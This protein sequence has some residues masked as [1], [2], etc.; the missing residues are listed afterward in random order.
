MGKNAFVTLIIDVLDESSY[1][2]LR[3]S[4]RFYRRFVGD[5]ITLR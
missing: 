1:T 4:I 5:A 2:M 3:S